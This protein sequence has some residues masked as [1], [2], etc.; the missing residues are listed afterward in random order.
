MFGIVL[1]RLNAVSFWKADILSGLNFWFCG[2]FRLRV[3]A[4][5]VKPKLAA[6]EKP[7]LYVVRR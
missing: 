6:E 7:F 4:K 1:L 3:F 5:R 2:R